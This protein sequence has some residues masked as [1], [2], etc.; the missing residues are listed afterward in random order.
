MS[1][2]RALGLLGLIVAGCAVGPSYKRPDVGA[3]AAWRPPSAIADSLHPFYD[4]LAT[5]RDTLRLNPG[6]VAVQDS[7]A[8][9]A[10]HPDTASNLAWFDLLADPVLRALVDSA[11]TQNRDVRV[12]VARIDEFRALAGV[13]KSELFPQISLNGQGGKVQTVLGSGGQF[14]YDYLQ[15]TA[16]LQWELDFWGRI[17][18]SSEAAKSEYLASEEIQRAV[19][20]SLVGDVAITYL[21][22]RELDSGLEISQ[23]TLDANLE[24]LKL[25]RRRFDEG[26][27][28]ELDVRRFES[29][30]AT[31][32]ASVANFEGQITQT[33]N[34][35]SLLIGRNP[36]AIT[37]GRPLTEVLG[38]LSVPAE[39]PE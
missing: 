14:K 32:A 5:H 28:S 38:T 16:D 35:L 4:S 11:L 29:S 37:R 31:P 25:A 6:E 36:G 1:L 33:E 8:Y 7:A 26:L 3:P 18:R 24:T 2:D 17:R 9:F 39:L 34:L 23:R 12:A 15:A 30:V 21:H 19:V 13:A 10:L 27:I 20:L 22:L